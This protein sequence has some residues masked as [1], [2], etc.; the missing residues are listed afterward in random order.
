MQTITNPVAL[1]LSEEVKRTV[2]PNDFVNETLNRRNE[3]EQ[4]R[5]YMKKREMKS[6]LRGER[7][8]ERKGV[9]MGME[10]MIIA[11]IQNNGSDEI[12]EAM[13][14]SAGITEAYL[15]ELKKAAL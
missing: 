10:K 13:R 3:L 15:A 9:A 1:E 2:A 8:G 14:K 12:I 11:A 5:A 4:L 7:K 6:K